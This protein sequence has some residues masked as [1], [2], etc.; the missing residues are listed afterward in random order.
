MG[1]QAAQA[2]QE[3]MRQVAE[4]AGARGLNGADLA[5][6]V[7]HYKAGTQQ[8]TQLEKMLG[9]IQSSEETALLNGQ[10][11]LDRS[12]ELPGQ[13]E[14]PIVNTIVQSAQRNL[15]VPGH[16]T[17]AAMDAAWKTFN[18]EYAKVIGG[19][20]TGAG[21]LTDSA[22]HEAEDT[23]RGNYSYDQ[24][25][26]AFNQMKQ[27]M[28]NRIAAIHSGLN[29]AYSRLTQQP[30][31][32]VPDTTAS[33]IAAARGDVGDSGSAAPGMGGNG[34][35]TPGGG[36]PTP[37]LPNDQL[38]PATGGTKEVY[39]SSMTPVRK[40]YMTRLEAGQSGTELVGFLRNAGI[41]DPALLQSAAQQAAFRR[42]H[43]DVPVQQYNTAAIDHHVQ[44]MG[45]VNRAV[46]AIGQAGG[47]VTAGVAA[48]GNSAL[49]GFGPD[50]VGA[51]GGNPEQARIVLDQ[52]GQ[53][54]P[55]ATL[56]GDIAGGTLAALGGEAALGA[57][58]IAPSFGRSLAADT[59]YGTATGA[60]NSPDNRTAGAIEGALAGAGGSVIGQGLAKGAS[61]VAR[62]VTNKDVATLADAGVNSLTPGQIVA[63]SGRAGQLVKGVE[64]RLAGYAGPGTM[65]NARRAEGYRQFNSGAFNQALKPIGA[66]VGD[67]TGEDAMVVAHQAVSD[68]FDGALKG[69]V[70]TPDD[71]FVTQARGPIERLA[72]NKRVG[73]E[74]VD[75]IEQATNGLFDPQTGALSG[76]HMQ[77]FLDALRQIRQGYKGD[78]LYQTLIKPSIQGLENAVEGMASR[79]A[80]EIMPQFNAAKAAYRRL[81]ILSDA[82]A[83]GQ[84]TEG[85]FSPAQ[86]GSAAVA[87]ARKF[88]GP[89]AKAFPSRPF[90]DY[91]RAAQNVLPSKVPDS[92]TAGRLALV[93][94]GGLTG[95]GAGA[96]YLSGDTKTGAETGLGLAGVLALAYTRAGNQRLAK[97]LLSRSPAARALAEKISQRVPIAGAAGTALMLP[98]P[99]Q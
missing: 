7:A 61:A 96:G 37:Q 36:S 3:I 74:I 60:G 89:M 34:P 5:R 26:A 15:P 41:T 88:D 79:Q 35:Q 68:A 85:V 33:L 27:D 63:N 4:Q 46:N 58:G 39:D 44:Q 9:Y 14:V 66:K 69:K 80:P 1:K 64:D 76:E 20:P 56:T 2:R 77:A 8:L 90:F 55:G 72:A 21:T 94:T 93:G 45:P 42:Q 95:L 16:D 65:I 48:A 43:P 32:L 57:A 52:L 87:N 11:F 92:G 84:N 24:K 51:T 40:E 29:E 31:Y 75:S 47:P 19:S 86:L 81:S 6:Q 71:A 25:L 10:Q 17:V 83:K 49:A 97:I 22:R 12:R 50:I 67:A 62:G 53:Q 23:M 54:N 70:L 98:G 73:P 82:V 59:A 78:P 99:S 18:S 28:A 38:T 30:G 91:Q 13:T